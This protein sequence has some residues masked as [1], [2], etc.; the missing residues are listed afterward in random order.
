MKVVIIL[1]LLEVVFQQIISYLIVFLHNPGHNPCFTGSCFSTHDGDILLPVPRKQ[2]IILV[3]LEVVF[4][5]IIVL[6]TSMVRN[7]S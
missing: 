6:D 5:Q 4:Q 7:M 3:L 1:V 2:V